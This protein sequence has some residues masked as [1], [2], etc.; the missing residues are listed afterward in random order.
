MKKHEAEKL[1][2]DLVDIIGDSPA[3]RGISD[4]LQA[5]AEKS[6]IT[7]DEGV[8]R[9]EL[10]CAGCKNRIDICGPVG[11]LLDIRTEVISQQPELSYRLRDPNGKIG[12]FAMN[13]AGCDFDICGRTE[14]LEAARD[15]LDSLTEDDNTLVVDNEPPRPIFHDIYR[16]LKIEE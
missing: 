8:G 14:G 13:T 5:W 15:I 1:L 2:A 10:G 9:L 4:E 6:Q 12:S 16:N 11:R 3:N 7:P